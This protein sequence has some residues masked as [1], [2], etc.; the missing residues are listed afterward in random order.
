MS[1]NVTLWLGICF[2]AKI[3]HWND[4]SRNK[5]MHI[6]RSINRSEFANISAFFSQFE[7][8]PYLKE[9]RNLMIIST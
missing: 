8:V 3:R 2:H 4:V 6:L 7:A 9:F 5:E 1:G